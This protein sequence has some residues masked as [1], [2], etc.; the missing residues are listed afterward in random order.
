MRMHTD[1]SSQFSDVLCSAQK[2]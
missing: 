2:Q 1:N